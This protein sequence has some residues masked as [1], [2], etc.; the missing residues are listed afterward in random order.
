MAEMNYVLVIV[1]IAALSIIVLSYIH[2]HVKPYRTKNATEV[3]IE[4]RDSD[5]KGKAIVIKPKKDASQVTVLSF[6][7]GIEIKEKEMVKPPDLFKGIVGI[8]EQHNMSSMQSLPYSSTPG[9]RWLAISYGKHSEDFVSNYQESEPEVM[10]MLNEIEEVL[11][12]YNIF[13]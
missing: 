6:D 11:K 7:K 4:V 2:G 8:A 3:R 1:A 5:V 10:S 13:T 12:K 9:K